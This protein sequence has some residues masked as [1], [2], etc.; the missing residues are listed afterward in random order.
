MVYLIRSCSTVYLEQFRAS[1]MPGSKATDNNVD[2]ISVVNSPS[3]STADSSQLYVKV[4]DRFWLVAEYFVFLFR[5]RIHGQPVDDET[6]ATQL[7]DLEM[8]SM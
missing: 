2:V 6:L 4:S 8:A 3:N 5:V 1:P 7:R